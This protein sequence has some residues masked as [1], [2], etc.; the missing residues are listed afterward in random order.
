MRILELCRGTVV[1]HFVLYLR[2]SYCQKQFRHF[3]DFGAYDLD[4]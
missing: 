2:V 4:L 3:R 1:E